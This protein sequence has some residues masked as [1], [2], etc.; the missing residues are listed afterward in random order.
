MT[1]PP[2]SSGEDGIKH[3]RPETALIITSGGVRVVCKVR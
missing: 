3:P 2:P 1:I